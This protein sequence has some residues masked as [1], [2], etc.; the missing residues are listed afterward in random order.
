[1]I[2]LKRNKYT[3]GDHLVISDDSGQKFLRSECVIDW[4][5]RMV[6]KQTEFSEKHPQLTIR[7]RKEHVAVTDGTR[8]QAEDLPLSDSSFNPSGSV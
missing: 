3:A 4:R 7:G 1:M 8:T 5:G 2:A 6:H